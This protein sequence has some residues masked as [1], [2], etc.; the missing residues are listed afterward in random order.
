MTDRRRK[1][2]K[3]PQIDAVSRRSSAPPPAE[4]GATSAVGGGDGHGEDRRLESILRSLP[5]KELSALA[6]RNGIKIDPNKR[7]DL[8]AQVARGLV[9]TPEL[10]EPD[11]LAGPSA[12][13]LKRISEAGG[14]LVVGAV[15]TGLEALVRRGI[16]FARMAD[17][18]LTDAYREAH[19]SRP[20]EHVLELVLPTALLVQLKAADGEDPRSLRALLADAPFETASAIATHYLG[21]PSAP[22]VALALE[23]AWEVLRDRRLLAQE[24]ERISHQER[25]LLDQIEQ[26]GGEVDTQELMDLER[27]PMRIRGAYGVA[28]GRRGAAFSL[29]K[30]GFLFPLHPNRYV[31]PTEVSALVGA[32]R[33]RDRE[34]LRQR[35]RNQVVD[36]DHLPRRARF[37]ADPAPLAMALALAVREPDANVEIKP[38]VGTPRSVVA[39]LGARFGCSP[40]ETALVVALSRAVGLWNSGASAP[41]APPGSLRLGALQRVL[42][43]AWRRGGAWD[44]ARQD[45]EVLRVPADA[46]DPSPVS[47]L[48]E[49]VLDALRELGDGQWVRYADL[50]DYIAADARLGGLHRLFERWARRVGLDTPPVVGLI[51]RILLESLPV[52]GIVDVG[53]VDFG[54]SGE[55]LCES[56]AIRINARGRALFIDAESRASAMASRSGSPDPNGDMAEGRLLSLGSGALVAD[57]LELA[58]FAKIVGTEPALK[59]EF[60]EASVGQGLSAGLTAS[61]MRRRIEALAPLSAEAARMFAEADVVLGRASFAPVAGFLWVDDPEIRELLRTGQGTADLFLDPSPDAGLLVVLGVEPERLARRC[62]VLGIEIA[63]EEPVMRARRSTVPPPRASD[64]GRKSRSWRPP[65]T[66]DTSSK[67]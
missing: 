6:E 59:L 9:R 65:A 49:V 5:A 37:S 27:E 48:R 24:F 7:L 25:R 36:E 33:Q 22:P 67:S 29:E 54:P 28:A 51:E 19:G 10:R 16:V 61:V 63:L 12:E 47:A 50:T 23:V 20:G 43:D 41:S 35:I 26:I 40:E 34:E 17:E 44:E 11:R 64:S 21:R 60:S 52:L 1:Q 4:S 38:G 13:L 45:A 58:P 14:V 55:R 18:Q 42:F 66:P 31:V 32:E 30:R 56:A 8:A 53:G 46:R 57:V 15:P 39:R 62:R 2:A 3:P